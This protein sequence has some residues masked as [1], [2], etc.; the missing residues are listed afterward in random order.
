MYFD[1]SHL[2]CYAFFFFFLQCWGLN[3]GPSPRAT[4][5]ALFCDGCFGD[6]ISQPICPDWL[7]TVILPIS[8]SWVTRITGVSHRH[9]TL[10]YC[11]LSSLP[12]LKITLI[13]FLIILFPYKH[14]MYFDHA[15]P[16]LSLLSPSLFLLA[17]ISH[18]SHSVPFSFFRSRF[19]TR[20]KMCDICLSHCWL[21][22]LNMM[23]SNSIHFP[24]NDTPL[25]VC[26]Y[27]FLQMILPCVKTTLSLALIS[28]WTPR[29]LL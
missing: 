8:A 16:L 27:H 22:S 18:A 12:P 17:P 6:K 1:Q 10:C 2:L 9:P 21:I 11:F 3:S 26:V 28:P 25:C 5:P 29:L 14:M 7:W 13:A 4:P 19:H 15:H 23:I 24:T 20:E